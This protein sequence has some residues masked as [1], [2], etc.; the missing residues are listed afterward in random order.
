MADCT[1]LQAGGGS[2]VTGGWRSAAALL[3]FV[4][5]TAAA[6]FAAR[7]WMAGQQ[8]YERTAGDAGC[9][10]R[11]GSC[12]VD[13]AGGSVALQITPQDI[14][15]MR[16]LTLAVVVDG[17]DAN[18][19]RIEIRGLNMDMGLNRTLLASLGGGRWQ[20]ETILPVCS[21]RHMEWEA[22]VQLDTGRRIEIPFHFRTLRP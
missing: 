6:F 17:L 19:V 7:H 14:P 9:D 22:A 5:L 8:V 2:G 10:L 21:Q 1:G 13:V 18:A 16:P 11:A 3:G 4:L 12:R 20:G 15:L